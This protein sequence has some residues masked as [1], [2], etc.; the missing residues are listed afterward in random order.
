[1]PTCN[2]Y[3]PYTV[4]EIQA[5]IKDI[6]DKITLYSGMSD[7]E[8]IRN[9]VDEYE[10]GDIMSSLSKENA[11]WQDMLARKLAQDG[12]CK[13]PSNFTSKLYGC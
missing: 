3:I 8:K 11:F 4:E 6:L 13:E 5:K 9:G 7:R 12:T 2:V 10:S 1:M